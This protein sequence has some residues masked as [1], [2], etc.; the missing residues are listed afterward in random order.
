MIADQFVMLGKTVPETNADGR[1]FVCTA[2][3]DLEL[4]MPLRV[5][6]MAMADCP[7]RFSI[8]RIPLER[9]TKDS[10]PESWKIRG[11]RSLEHHWQ[12]NSVITEVARKINESQQRDILRALAVPSLAEANQRRLS[13]CVIY[14]TRVP[15]L[16]FAKAEP[17]VLEPTPDMFGSRSELPV[18][19]RF[20]YHPRLVFED[21]GGEHDLMLRDWGCYEL[22]RKRGRKANAEMSDALNLATAPPLLCGN[23]N[24]FRN[25]WLVISVFSGS[26]HSR[27][28]IVEEQISL[29]L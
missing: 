2:G 6:P 15:R 26:Q 1:L 27:P 17:K 23:L 14:P 21:E 25:S 12:I 22:M 29:Q 18:A 16:T 13:L 20:Q 10:R 3:Y 24:Q 9:N 5:Y 19:D 28:H 8:S 4:K 7:K 11:D